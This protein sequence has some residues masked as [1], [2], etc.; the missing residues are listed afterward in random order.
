MSVLLVVGG[1]S[2]LGLEFV[3]TRISEGHKVVVLSRQEFSLQGVTSITCD[4]SNL[5]EVSIIIKE[6]SSSNLTFDS[7]LFFQRSRRNPDKDSWQSE[8]DVT[9]SSTRLFLQ[10][11]SSILSD[12]GDKSIVIV[13]SVAG[14]FITR[15]ATDSYQI[16]K[17]ALLHL[18][19]YYAAKLGKDGIRINTVTPFTF[20]KDISR[21]Y[22]ESSNEWQQ[23][24]EKRIPLGRIC[25]PIDIINLIDFLRGDKAQYI[26]GQEIFI[27]GGLSLSLGVDF[28]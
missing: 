23:I 5:Q 2:G 14:T 25:T 10:S 12:D 6:L 16:S 26:T 8:F 22:F 9:V 4:L 13:N 11:S 20:V 24:V 27:D 28:N 19:R 7:L 3:N 1:T 18:A 21:N 15:D 17:A